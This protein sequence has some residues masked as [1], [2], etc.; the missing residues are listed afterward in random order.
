M[1]L[2]RGKYSQADLQFEWMWDVQ[3]TRKFQVIGGHCSRWCG[4][5]IAI[6]VARWSNAAREEWFQ[7]Q[8]KEGGGDLCCRPATMR[9]PDS[10]LITQQI[11]PYPLK[12]KIKLNNKS[13]SFVYFVKNSLS[14][15]TKG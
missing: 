9:T 5:R 7:V 4:D 15:N 13:I 6:W 10:K 12:N 14:E 8:G 2:S 1:G 11:F 3:C